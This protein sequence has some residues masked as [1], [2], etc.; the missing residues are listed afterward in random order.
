MAMV[1]R[2][3]LVSDV[4]TVLAMLRESA[5]EQGFEDAVAVTEANLVEDGF[6]PAPRFYVLLADLDG[7]PAGMALYFFNY[8]T[9]GSRDGLYLEDLY[10]GSAFRRR[11]VGRALLARLAQVALARGCGRFQW[12]VQGG[13]ANAVRMY[14]AAGAELLTEW[15]L[16][17]L[18]GD[19]I[20]RLAA[21]SE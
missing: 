6:G 11:G 14:E 10:V 7:L 17:S 3:A 18:K 20:A 21:S 5:F 12:V 2:E 16:M 9:W 1:I 8:S 19:A 15:R 13:K 4:P